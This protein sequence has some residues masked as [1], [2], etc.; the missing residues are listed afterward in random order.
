[1]LYKERLNSVK[2]KPV[3]E[4]CP[5][6]ERRVYT[7]IEDPLRPYFYYDMVIRHIPMN[8]FSTTTTEQLIIKI[9]RSMGAFIPQ[10]QPSDDRILIDEITLV[11][12]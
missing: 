1:M 7:T 2:D 6:N 10:G 11:K 12:Q 3:C 8:P 9:E 4:V 5:D